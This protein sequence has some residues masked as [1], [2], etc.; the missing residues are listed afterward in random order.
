MYRGSL[1][2]PVIV[3]CLFSGISVALVSAQSE[4]ITEG[5]LRVVGIEAKK[6]QLCPLKSTKVSADVRGFVSR[7]TV[8]QSFQNP[9]D[10]AIEAVYTFPL[11]NDA[12]VDNM[13]IRIGD[14]TIKGKIMERQKAREA[15][16]KA[17]QEGKVTALLDQERPNIFTQSVANIT[18]NAEIQ[19]VIEYVETLKYRDD[20]YEFTFPMTIGERYIP[21]STEATAA[22]RISPKSKRRPGHTISIDLKIDAGVPI[23]EITSRTHP[24]SSQQFSPTEYRISLAQEDEIP[25]RDL[26]VKYKTAGTKIDDAILASKDDRGGFFTLILQPPDRV[27]PADTTPKEIVFV[28]DTSGSMEGF[29]I[30]K[31]KE[32]M[33][34][35]LDSLN[36]GDT[37][38]TGGCEPW[39]YY[40]P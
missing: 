2:I 30:R 40:G 16:D 19:V 21:S 9:F 26:V 25:N 3:V 35:T 18:P 17:K 24:I 15:Y 1:L 14:R 32:A 27:M 38:D 23:Q 39:I 20:A 31:A 8:T 10:R 7:V 13:T 12:A 6:P 36:P 22:A 29:P 34:L 11:P 33:N 37:F 5:S 4:K 28:L